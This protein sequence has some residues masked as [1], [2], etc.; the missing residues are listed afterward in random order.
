MYLSIF[1]QVEQP[2]Q[3][4]LAL[5][6]ASLY[7]AFEQ[8]KDS[9]KARGKRYPLALLLT[10]LMVGKMAGEKTTNGIVD[11]I[12]E[13]EDWL[14]QHLNWP[15]RFPVNSTY[16][17]ALAGCNAQEIVQAIAQVIVKAR[18]EEERKAASSLKKEEQEQLLHTAMDGK[19]LR[20]TLG[21]AQAEQPK[22]HLLSLYECESGI[23]IAQEA[24]ESK[25]NEITAAKAFADPLFVKG[26]I[27]TADSMHT[28]KTWCASV[29]AYG[30]Y[31]LAVA[32]ENQPGVLEDLTDF[33]EDKDPETYEWDDH[34]QV[35][36]GHGR[37]DTREI[38][39]STQMNTWFEQEWAGIAQVF[40]I[41]RLRKKREKEEEEIV[42][43]L[44]NL[45]RNK[46]NA[47]RLLELNQKHWWIENRLHY[48][49]DVTLGEDAC[50]VR[51]KHVP[52]VLA[53]LNGGVLA[54][55]DY[56]G[57]TNVAKQ[58][59]HFCAQPQEA[60]QLLVGK[61]SR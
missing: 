39:T 33:F 46:A 44:T 15:R 24:V 40:K 47:E 9:R 29:H 22:V 28:Q 34:K 61:L 54:I 23:V 48:R 43:G 56:L 30:G 26:R 49:R 5:D 12:K 51:V 36:K 6:V 32:K 42:Y 3:Q 2:D 58:M 55:M 10:L 8:V 41:R 14:K 4:S 7:C 35:Q 50:Q 45:P 31:Y 59:R 27:I 37:L 16:T 19:T 17:E 21:H 11:W 60:L 18:A 1:E 38:W 20:G 13:R 52:Q 57:V 53:A 25:E